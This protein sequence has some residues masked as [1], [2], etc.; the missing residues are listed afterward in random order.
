VTGALAYYDYSNA[1]KNAVINTPTGSGA[2]TAQAENFNELNPT[3][4]IATRFGALPA[5]VFAEYVHNTAA[6][7][8]NDG[9][10]VGFKL[11]NA[12]KPWS[13]TE[14]WEAG[15]FFQR[16]EADAAFDGFVDGDINGGGTNHR[17]H[18]YFTTLA[19]LANS[20]VTLKYFDAEELAVSKNREDRL[21]VDWVTKF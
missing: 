13:L 21:Q 11:G 20:A 2:N 6:A 9:Y 3:V 5:S 7:S 15:Y 16:L 4:A 18:A 19:V 10:H 8:Y 12:V 1:F 14:G 17:G